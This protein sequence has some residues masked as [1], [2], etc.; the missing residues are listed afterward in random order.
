MI[1]L[2]RLDLC[3]GI[4]SHIADD[5]TRPYLQHKQRTRKVS[6]PKLDFHSY[7]TMFMSYTIKLFLPAQYA[8]TAIRMEIIEIPKIL[9]FMLLLQIKL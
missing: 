4:R 6:L 7:A 2:L 9:P 8:I 3:H 5:Q 1:L